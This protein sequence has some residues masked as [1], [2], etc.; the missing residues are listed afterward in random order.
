MLQWLVPRKMCFC[1]LEDRKSFTDANVGSCPD[2]VTNPRRRTVYG[3]GGVARR[4]YKYKP[5][6]RIQLTDG[7]RNSMDIAVVPACLEL[8]NRIHGS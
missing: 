7:T 2:R 8:T 3:T 1:F 5:T 4:S 6:A